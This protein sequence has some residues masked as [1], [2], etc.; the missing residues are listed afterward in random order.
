MS[1]LAGLHYDPATAVTTKAM[2][3]NIAMVA[4]DTTNLR[5]TFTAPASGKVLV[6]ISGGAI[7]GGIT[8]PSALIGV[9]EGSTIR[10][11]KAP[12]IDA[13]ASAATL[14]G[15]PRTSFVVTGLTPSTS[16]TWD[17]AYGVETFVAG[18]NWKYGGPNDTT[19]NNAW[20]GI[21]F[22]IWD[23][24]ACLAAAFYDPAVAVTKAT[25]TVGAVMA[26]L[27]TTNLRLT[28]TVPTSGK[29]MV[30]LSGGAMHGATTPAS[31]HLGVLE[32]TT[33]KGRKPAAFNVGTAA[34]TALN[35][36]DVRFLVTG[37]SS[38]T[39]LTWD[40]A[41][42]IEQFVTSTGYKYGGPND[43]TANNAFGGISFEIWQVD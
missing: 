36:P 17:V 5:L 25:A 4:V 2:T 13:G 27:D 31:I 29:V 23:A 28:F 34:T 33:T 3:S 24:T 1:L 14:H 6:S 18:A 35:V 16:Y 8:Y 40:A 21:T 20:G 42:A 41:F 39:S 22:E 9:L 11:R 12:I 15:V 32:S 19:V 43:T 10:G 38:G 30:C 7:H 26:A 37:L